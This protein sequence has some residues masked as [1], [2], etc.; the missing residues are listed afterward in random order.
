MFYFHNNYHTV[1]CVVKSYHLSMKCQGKCNIEAILSVVSCD[2]SQPHMPSRLVCEF[3]I[4]LYLVKI[5]FKLKWRKLLFFPTDKDLSKTMEGLSVS[6]PKNQ[7]TVQR[8]FVFA[9]LQ[10]LC[11][12]FQQILSYFFMNYAKSQTM[13]IALQF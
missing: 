7:G 2:E 10:E 9:G 12:F 13:Q 4:Y 1:F 8:R 6:P 3:V 5:R 11:I